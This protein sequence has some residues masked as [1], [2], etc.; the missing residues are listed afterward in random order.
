MVKSKNTTP[1]V[2]YFTR[3]ELRDVV[4]KFKVAAA[5]GGLDESRNS[6]LDTSSARM[7]DE[8]L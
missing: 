3:E 7:F 2:D 8:A 4:R 6:I 1:N 5:T